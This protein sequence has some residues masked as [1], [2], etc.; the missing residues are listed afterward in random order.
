MV[1]GDWSCLPLLMTTD[2]YYNDGDGDG[3]GDDYG[4]LKL[5]C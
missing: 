3:N 5:F 1:I 4:N 2:D